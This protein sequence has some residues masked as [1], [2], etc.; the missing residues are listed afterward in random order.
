M[1]TIEKD[2]PRC[3][4][5]SPT[6]RRC[7]SKAV[8]G[9]N[10]CHKHCDFDRAYGAAAEIVSNRDRLDTAE[11]VHS[12]LAR[13]ARALAA[14]KIHP[15]EATGLTYVGQTL[16]L[17]LPRLLEERQKLFLADEED[18]WRMKALA[19]SYHDELVCEDSPAE[20]EQEEEETEEVQKPASVQTKRK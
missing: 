5:R 11:G 9:W 18:A 16:L 15:R 1:P 12:F 13:I 7:Q 2:E 17:S 4:Y 6:A 8:P 19:D 14:G 20:E 3:A 10:M